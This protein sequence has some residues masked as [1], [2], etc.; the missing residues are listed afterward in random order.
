MGTVLPLLNHPI[1]EVGGYWQSDKANITQM[2]APL[3]SESPLARMLRA[4]PVVRTV[5]RLRLNPILVALIVAGY[6]VVHTLALPA[7]FGLLHTSGGIPGALDDWPNLV[8]ILLL[9]PIIAGY[10]VWQP[11]VIQATFDAVAGRAGLM[12]VAARR[13]AE[14]MRPLGWQVWHFIAIAVGLALCVSEIVRLTSQPLLTWQNA[15]WAMIASRLPLRFAVFYAIV[16]LIVRQTVILF[17]LIDSF[18]SSRLRYS[19]STQI[20][21]AACACWATMCC[22]MVCSSAWLA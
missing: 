18:W 15:N 5:F 3:A 13:A 21:L 19:R 1:S 9:V 10:Y 7:W 2:N 6:G 16:F 22:P 8:I 12:P 4:D 20:E 14:L 11:S 17:G